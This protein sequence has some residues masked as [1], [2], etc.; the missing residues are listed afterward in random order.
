MTPVS[1]VKCLDSTTW[2]QM[3][4]MFY[5]CILILYKII[6]TFIC[7]KNLTT[8]TLNML[9]NITETINEFKILSKNITVQFFIYCNI[10]INIKKMFQLINLKF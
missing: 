4:A 9:V 2:Y 10:S 7:D 5:S 8:E 1:S 3:I 6:Y